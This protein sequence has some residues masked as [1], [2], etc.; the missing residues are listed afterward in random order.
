MSINHILL[1]PLLFKHS[2][3]KNKDQNKKQKDYRRND[4]KFLGVLLDSTLS[5]KPHITE[6]SKNFQKLLVSFTNC[7]IMPQLMSYNFYTIH[8]FILVGIGENPT[9]ILLHARL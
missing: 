4:V 7:D 9:P 5:W 8:Y 6:L 3:Q 1:F 2:S